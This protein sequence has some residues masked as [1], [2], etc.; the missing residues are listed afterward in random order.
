MVL[1]EKEIQFQRCV[2]CSDKDDGSLGKVTCE[3]NER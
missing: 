1:N 2:M 3:H